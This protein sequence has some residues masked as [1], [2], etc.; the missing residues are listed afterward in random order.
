MKIIRGHKK[1]KDAMDDLAIL[2]IDILK[3]IAKKHDLLNYETNS[4]ICSFLGTEVKGMLSFLKKQKLEKDFI[5]FKSIMR[6]VI[7]GEDLK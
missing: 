1:I 7:D 4:L 5:N 6:K 2:H 3:R